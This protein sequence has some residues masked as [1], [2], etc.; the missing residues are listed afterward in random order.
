[1]SKKKQERR[2]RITEIVLERGAVSVD[3]LAERLDV[4][5]QTI[6]RDI[7]KLCESDMLRRRHGR[8]ELAEQH[9]NTP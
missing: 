2:E 9:A 8:V 3:A 6:R 5:T 7:D 4:S 1:M